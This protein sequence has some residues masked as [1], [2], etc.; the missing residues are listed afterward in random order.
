[1]RKPCIAIFVAVFGFYMLTSSREPAWGDA[2][3]MWEVAAR[4]VETGGID[5][6]TRWPD[7]IPPGPDGKI[8]GIAA[9]GD[10]LPHVPGAAV[11]ALSHRIA[12]SQDALVRPLATHVAPAALGALAAVLFF[13]LLLDLGVAAR[14]PSPCPPIPPCATA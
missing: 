5:I 2:H 7:D 13:L 12:P 9:I 6:K 14:A 10:A 4:I 11:A 8:Y 1:M 3:P